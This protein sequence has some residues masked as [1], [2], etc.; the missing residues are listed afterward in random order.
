MPVHEHVRRPLISQKFG[1]F[2]RLP[3][4]RP[5]RLACLQ[6]ARRAMKG[7]GTSLI[8]LHGPPGAGK[9]HL[10]QVVADAIGHGRSVQVL[11]GRDLGKLMSG[12]TSDEARPPRTFRCASLLVIEDV[13]HLPASAAAAVATLLDYRQARRLATLCTAAMGP[14]ALFGLPARLTTR[15]ASGLVVRMKS[16][17][18]ASLKKL[19]RWWRRER[20]VRLDNE[21]ID[22]L[23]SKLRAPRGVRALFGDLARLQQ[24]GRERPHRFD[25]A[26]AQQ[27]LHDEAVSEVQPIRAIADLVATRFEL[28]A[29]QLQ[30]RNRRESLLWP[31]QIAMYAARRMTDLSLAAIGSYFGGCDHTTVLHAIRKVQQ[32]VSQDPELAHEIDELLS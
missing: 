1:R 7:A 31:R 19:A 30:S 3:E 10:V 21:V 16:L 18:A 12:Q 20:G 11:P 5:A 13:Q 6:F 26:T 27:L 14:T 17:G 24:L 15:M 29:E 9:S 28:T 23:V 32:R 25:L 8:Y 22:W 4:N 2:I